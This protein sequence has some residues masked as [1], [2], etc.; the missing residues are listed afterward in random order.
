M[1]L[2]PAEVKQ[3]YKL[4]HTTLFE[5]ENQGILKPVK[6]A[7]GH[8][9][10]RKDEIEELLKMNPEDS[11]GYHMQIYFDN[12]QTMPRTIEIVGHTK[13][14][15]DFDRVWWGT[16]GP[17]PE[18]DEDKMPMLDLGKYYRVDHERTDTGWNIKGHPRIRT[19]VA[20]RPPRKVVLQ[21]EEDTGIRMSEKKLCK[22]FRKDDN[23][24]QLTMFDLMEYLGLDEKKW[25]DELPCFFTSMDAKRQSDVIDMQPVLYELM[26]AR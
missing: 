5:L 16:D 2:R 4:S 18:Y 3:Y 21:G 23:S 22:F 12:F 7:G 19:M 20:S 17:P 11:I 9:R 10:Y 15:P 14:E 1:L 26:E 6:T 13:P 24:I 25:S 8:R